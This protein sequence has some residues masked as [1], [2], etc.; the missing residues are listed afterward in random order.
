MRRAATLAALA[1]L[2]ACAPEHDPPETPVALPPAPGR[3]VIATETV[4]VSAFL[5]GASASLAELNTARCA[6]R[7]G[8]QSVAFTTPRNVAIPIHDGPAD[9]LDISCTAAIGPREART[10]LR[11][12]PLGGTTSGGRRYPATITLRFKQ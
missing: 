12:L 3:S 8:A 4:T 2:S 5:A 11:H 6:L 10:A 9:P 1:L 7:R